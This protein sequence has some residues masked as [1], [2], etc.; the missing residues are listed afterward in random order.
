M[1]TANKYVNMDNTRIFL[2]LFQF[3]ICVYLV[4]LYFFCY[5]SISVVKEMLLFT[6]NYD[7]NGNSS[8]NDYWF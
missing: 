1:Q 4:T 2:L 5:L 8:R 6:L 3:R 7:T